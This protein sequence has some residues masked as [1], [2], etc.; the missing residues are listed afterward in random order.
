MKD[1]KLNIAEVI[2][3]FKKRFHILVIITIITTIVGVLFSLFIVKPL[4]TSTVKLFIDTTKSQSTDNNYMVN[5]EQANQVLM[6]T[7]IGI[8]KTNSLIQNVINDN[9]L[10][11]KA[12]SVMT[13]LTVK[14]EGSSKILDISYKSSSENDIQPLLNGLVKE[15]TSDITSL[16]PNT[17]VTVIEKPFVQSNKSA[18]TKIAPVVVGFAIGIAISIAVILI[19]YCLDN[20]IKTRS[21]LEKIL[22]IPVLGIIPN[23]D[24]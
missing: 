15:F 20:T 6:N 18:S 23:S 21:E 10:N 9:H 1:E 14:N 7:S 8:L 13:G 16:V 5:Q 4:Y 12:G 19:L 17:K 11:L 2:Y 22:D 24:K 3:A